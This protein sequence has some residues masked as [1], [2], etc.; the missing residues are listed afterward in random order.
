MEDCIFCK[1]IKGE[2]KS[3]ILYET[4]DFII[5]NERYIYNGN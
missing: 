4:E 1:I 5:I 2:I 3:E